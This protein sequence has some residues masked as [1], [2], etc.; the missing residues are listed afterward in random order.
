MAISFYYTM[1][2]KVSCIVMKK[3]GISKYIYQNP[4]V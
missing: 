4:A 2:N 3:K 1:F